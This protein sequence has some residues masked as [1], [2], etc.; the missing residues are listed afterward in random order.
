MIK[1][2]VKDRII[3][4]NLNRVSEGIRVIE[5]IIRFYIEDR[6]KL[7]QIR[8]LKRELWQNVSKI[9]NEVIWSRKSEQD[10][11]RVNDFDKTKRV[12]ISD[13][14]T[15]NI[16]RGQ[17]SSRVLEEMF[18][19]ENNKISGFFKKL[20]FTLYDLEK[21]LSTQF[22]TQ[23]DPKLYVIIDIET[24]SRKHLKEITQACV[25][26][27][28]TMI[29]LREPKHTLTKKWLSDAIKIKKAILNP[30]NKLIINDR[31][32]I[33][34]AVDADGV[35]LGKYDMPLS[36]ARKLLGDGRIIGITVRNEQQASKAERNGADYVSVGSIFPSP[37]KTTAP[38]VG[39][40]RLKEIIKGVKIP[41]VA[42]G[43]INPQNAKQLFRL[44]VSGIAVVSS[45]FN[46]TDFSKKNFGIQII[47]N[48]IELKN[49]FPKS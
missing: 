7:K 14:F 42:I 25:L 49:A 20:R 47:K 10:L 43:G 15:A 46:D 19:P 31:I 32:D 1:S 38:V 44:G 41:V 30:K 39:S 8:D 29:Q 21:D 2:K 45:V 28:A 36:Y 37:T 24:L 35:H 5:E 12:T 9:R 17:E 27:G 16:K 40:N 13:I 34:L 11:G 18:K 48:L 33:A 23:F 3:D 6:Q 22:L 26:G 4:V